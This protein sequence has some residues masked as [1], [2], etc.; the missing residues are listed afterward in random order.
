MTE[1]CAPNGSCVR[2]RKI[3]EEEESLRQNTPFLEKY[4][5]VSSF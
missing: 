3:M 4:G 2:M 5:S 1:R